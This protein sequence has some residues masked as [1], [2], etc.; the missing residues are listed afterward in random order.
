MC[1]TGAVSYTH[2]E[3]FKLFRKNGLNRSFGFTVSKLSFCLSFKLRLA[4]FYIYYGSY[5]LSDIVSGKR[6]RCV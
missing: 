6:L 1:I 5:A 4:Y 3:I 2:L